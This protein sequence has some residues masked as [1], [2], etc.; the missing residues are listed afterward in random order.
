M[1]AL[2]K[3]EADP[4]PA[5]EAD[6]VAQ[7]MAGHIPKAVKASE[8]KAVAIQDADLTVEEAEVMT[9]IL[10]EVGE[11][12][13]DAKVVMEVSKLAKEASESV[14]PELVQTLGTLMD[15]L[16]TEV[17]M[18]EIKVIK[19]RAVMRRKGIHRN[20]TV[21]KILNVLQKYLGTVTSF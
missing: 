5:K 17:D 13:V 12:K 14:S 16:T 11:D 2:S 19:V 8:V 18:E 4:I 3:S 10:M 21:S 7:V 1:A 6:M 15:P 20:L 9:E